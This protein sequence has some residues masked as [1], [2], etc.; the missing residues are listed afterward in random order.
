[1]T[2]NT[3]HLNDRAS[4]GQGHFALKLGVAISLL[5]SLNAMLLVLIQSGVFSSHP[6]PLEASV[7]F[8]AT[9]ALALYFIVSAASDMLSFGS[10]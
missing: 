2:R 7:P 5:V 8:F 1:M 9:L 6:V 3:S 10:K 4:T